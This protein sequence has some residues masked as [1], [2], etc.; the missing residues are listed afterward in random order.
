[1]QVSESVTIRCPC[2][3]AFAF[4]SSMQGF[5]RHFPLAIDWRSGEATGWS[6]GSKLDFSMG[7]GDWL[8]SRVFG[9]LEQR[10]LK[11]RHLR[12]KQ[13]LECAASRGRC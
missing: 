11:Q 8:D 1:M 9:R 2:E 10:T 3:R 13:A 12:L 6:V 5:C 4:C 7:L